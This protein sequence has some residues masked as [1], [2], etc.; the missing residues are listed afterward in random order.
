MNTVRFSPKYLAKVQQYFWFAVTASLVH[1]VVFLDKMAR[2]SAY[3]Y[4]LPIKILDSNTQL[5]LLSSSWGSH[6]H[7]PVDSLMSFTFWKMHVHVWFQPA[8][9]NCK[10]LQTTSIN[11]HFLRLISSGGF[12]P[13][14]LP[15][16]QSL[17]L[18]T[19][20]FCHSNA[21]FCSSAASHRLLSLSD[22]HT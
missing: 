15:Y 7:Q 14:S 13:H 16:S 6:S 8:Y 4:N 5:K 21:S 1:K 17:G 11:G 20:I 19:L 3:C 10:F 12:L 2:L 22:L 9:Q 18:D